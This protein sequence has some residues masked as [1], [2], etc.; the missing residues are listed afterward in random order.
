MRFE[1]KIAAND[2]VKSP[3]LPHAQ[4]RLNIEVAVND[5]LPGYIGCV[6]SCILQC[7]RQPVCVV[8]GKL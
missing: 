1:N 2:D 6:L 3:A 8:A 4:G 5:P 7:A